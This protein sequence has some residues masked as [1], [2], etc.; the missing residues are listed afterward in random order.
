MELLEDD[1]ILLFEWEVMTHHTT[2]GKSL[3]YQRLY[4]YVES[5]VHQANW[6]ALKVALY[7]NHP[8]SQILYMWKHTQQKDDKAEW[9]FSFTTLFMLHSRIIKLQVK[10]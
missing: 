7:S 2:C 10:L 9:C 6:M 4:Y 5:T 1:I 8:T 3:K